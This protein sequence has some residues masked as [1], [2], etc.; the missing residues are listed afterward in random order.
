MVGNN[1][2]K[3]KTINAM[4]NYQTA[5]L[6]ETMG[7]KNLF[8]S[9]KLSQQQHKKLTYVCDL[10]IWYKLTLKELKSMTQNPSVIDKQHKYLATS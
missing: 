3:A 6:L 1:R 10:A 9:Q 2:R 8:H 4:L 5:T 7:R